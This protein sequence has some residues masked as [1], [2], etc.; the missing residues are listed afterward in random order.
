MV[1]F[2]E[3]AGVYCRFESREVPD[4]AGQLE[5]TV[6]YPDGNER[7][8]RFVNSK[9]LIERQRQIESELAG[10]GWEG[11]FGRRL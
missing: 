8:E 11:P 9:A 1:W 6:L 4:R 3:R 10:D 5:L 2:Y 7:T